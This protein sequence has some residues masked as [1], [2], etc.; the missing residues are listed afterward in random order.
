MIV[1]ACAGATAEPLQTFAIGF[2]EEQVN[3]LP[4]A[5]AVADRY[6]TR[7]VEHV[8][9]PDAVSLLDELAVAVRK[10]LGKTAEEL[11]LACI[12]EG[13]T[14]AAG[15]ELALELRKCLRGFL[16]RVSVSGALRELVELLCGNAGHQCV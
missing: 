6:G 12:L 3:E 16:F 10:E 13:G 4:Y 8:V 11:P 14:W 1:A 2:G 5:R 9:T 15:R 7:H